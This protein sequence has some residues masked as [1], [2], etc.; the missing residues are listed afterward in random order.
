M[1][2]YSDAFHG[3]VFRYAP[4]NVVM[5]YMHCLGMFSAAKHMSSD[6]EDVQG[7]YQSEL[8]CMLCFG[9]NIV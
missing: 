4:C 8:F 9:L 6:M 2:R 1:E 3:C 5:L 7:A